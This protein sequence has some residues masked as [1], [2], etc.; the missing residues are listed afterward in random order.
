MFVRETSLINISFNFENTT[1]F[2][3]KNGLSK[4]YHINNYILYIRYL[5]I[6]NLKHKLKFKIRFNKTQDTLL[7]FIT[8]HIRITNY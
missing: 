7:W 1:K 3:K 2:F 4:M 8:L 5:A 6:N